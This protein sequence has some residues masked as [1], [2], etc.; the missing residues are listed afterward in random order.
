MLSI[1]LLEKKTKFTNSVKKT[2]KKLNS[3]TLV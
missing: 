3:K 1:S 2:T